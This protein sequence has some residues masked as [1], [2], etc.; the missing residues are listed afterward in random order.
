MQIYRFYVLSSSDDPENI[1]YVG[2]TT[3]TIKQRMCG[4]KYNATHKEKRVQPVHKW[5][6]SKIEK[7]FTINIKEIDQCDESLW[8]I[9]EQKWI[10]YYKDL[11]YD[12]LNV[13]KGGVGVITKEIREV[14]GIK[15]S[16]QAHETPI[17]ALNDDKKV[18]YKF[19]SVKEA[20]KFFKLKG[21]TAISNALN[22]RSPKSCG[23]YWVYKKDYDAGIINIDEFSK[24]KKYRDKIQVKV[25][26]FDL[27]GNLIKRYD[28]ISQ[29]YKED[30]ISEHILIT[31]LQTNR[32]YNNFIY[33]KD[34]LLNISLLLEK[35][36]PY[37]EININTNEIVDKFRNYLEISKKFNI[38]Q[39]NICN[40]IKN[41]Q[42][43]TENTK[44]VKIKI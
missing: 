7:G 27:S 29:C 2:T 22:R 26:K 25:Y 18:V 34:P 10:R 37:H 5:M 3:R 16:A 6:W 32:I 14:D 41:Q 12:L 17:Y 9:T 38:S 19:N 35:Q 11:G 4:H 39:S 23:Y 31:N 20:T 44:I 13:S 1:R 15:R 40:R 21:R 42:K 33:S 8:E 30:N 36:F 43:F 28:S 24:L